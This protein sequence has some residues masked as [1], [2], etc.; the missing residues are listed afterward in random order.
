MANR[1]VKQPN[2][3][4]ARFSDIVDHFTDFNLSREE[5]R[6]IYQDQI[7][8]EEAIEKLE[9]AD[10]HAERFAK[11]IETIRVIHGAEEAERYRKDLSEEK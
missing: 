3:L 1:A 10:H 4:Y 6:Q 11:S 8:R 9:R 2:G 5:L 7:G